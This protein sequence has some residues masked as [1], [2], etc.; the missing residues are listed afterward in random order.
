MSLADI[1]K[2][3]GSE[4]V[5]FFLTAVQIRDM[6]FAISF[7]YCILVVSFFPLISVIVRLTI[8]LVLYAT[9]NKIYKS[10]GK[11]QF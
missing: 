8:R 7:F 3:R 10:F 2:A 4:N 5:T 9:K 11:L 6:V 1:S